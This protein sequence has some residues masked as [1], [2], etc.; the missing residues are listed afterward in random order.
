MQNHF[1]FKL[2]ILLVILSF[3]GFSCSYEMATGQ[4]DDLKQQVEDFND[5]V[6]RKSADAEVKQFE[7]DDIKEDYTKRVNQGAPQNELDLIVS[8]HL[9]CLDELQ[10]L[11]DAY[12]ISEITLEEMQQDLAKKCPEDLE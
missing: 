10:A 8:N 3:S 9:A 7:C 5:D 4:C 6:D 2:L 1:W 12:D 11:E